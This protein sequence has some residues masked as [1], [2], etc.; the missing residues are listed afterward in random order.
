MHPCTSGAYI[1][2]SPPIC[3]EHLYE[4]DLPL[5]PSFA[6]SLLSF[7]PSFLFTLLLST[8]LALPLCP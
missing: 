3:L 4:L 5:N 2:H 6:L 8:H 7:F 1:H